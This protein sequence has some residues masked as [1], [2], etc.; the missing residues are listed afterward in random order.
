MYKLVNVY[1][2]KIVATFESHAE[3]WAALAIYQNCV[4][5]QS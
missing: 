5:I 4:L 3:A 2:Y 1:T